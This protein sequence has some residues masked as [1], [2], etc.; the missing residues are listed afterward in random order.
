M[1]NCQKTSSTKAV[2]ILLATYISFQHA[3]LEKSHQ[4]TT[5]MAALLPPYFNLLTAPR[6]IYPTLPGGRNSAPQI[7]RQNKWN[8]PI[9]MTYFLTATQNQSQSVINV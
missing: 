7:R 8:V 1:S 3:A 9:H 6:R 5:P 2:Q 4:K